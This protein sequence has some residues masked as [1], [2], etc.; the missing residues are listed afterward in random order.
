[1]G[2]RVDDFRALRILM[3]VE[4]EISTNFDDLGAVDTIGYLEPGE[5][6]EVL[7]SRADDEVGVRLKIARG[8]V[9]RKTTDG[10]VAMRRFTQET[11][12]LRSQTPLHESQAGTSAHSHVIKPR[13]TLERIWR[14]K[15]KRERS[16]ETR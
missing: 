15:S 5:V 16:L 8:W 14:K 6:V 12:S 11:S 10:Q 2:T 3:L 7:R 4:P 13:P 9:S 1:M